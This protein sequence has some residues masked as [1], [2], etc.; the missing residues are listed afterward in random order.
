[1]IGAHNRCATTVSVGN[2][3]IGWVIRGVERHVLRLLAGR[4]QPCHFLVAAEG[5]EAPHSFGWLSSWYD[6]E[7]SG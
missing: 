2:G 1:V 7:V 5:V 3:H 4:R 6:G